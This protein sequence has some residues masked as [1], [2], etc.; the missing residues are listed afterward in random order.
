MAHLERRLLKNNTQDRMSLARWNPI[1][2]V[3]WANIAAMTLLID[4]IA[5]ISDA[6]AEF[7]L[8]QRQIVLIL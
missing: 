1:G 8:A 5:T 3:T 7:E 2:A 6:T 4:C